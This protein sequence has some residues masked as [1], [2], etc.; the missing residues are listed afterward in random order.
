MGGAKR[1]GKMKTYYGITLDVAKNKVKSRRQ[2]DF[3]NLRGKRNEP[4]QR[5][6]PDTAPLQKEY[7]AV[8]R[9]YTS[10]ML[11]CINLTIRS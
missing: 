5:S 8:M 9:L 4:C 10:S 7:Y 1:L 6:L 2:A 3:G 11:S